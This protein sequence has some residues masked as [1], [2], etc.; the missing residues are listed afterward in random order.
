MTE[1]TNTKPWL[2]VKITD[3]TLFKKLD[4][5]SA[6]DERDRSKFVRWLIQQE[7]E[8]RN[9]ALA[10]EENNKVVSEINVG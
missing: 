5:M 10:K 9:A 2:H 3:H 1:A 6:A 7:W 4:A 8:R